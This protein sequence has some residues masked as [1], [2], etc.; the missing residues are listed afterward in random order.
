MGGATAG[1]DTVMTAGVVPCA[2]AHV[3]GPTMPSGVIPRCACHVFVAATVAGPNLP[4][5][6]TPM[7]VC[8]STT[9][10]P[11]DPCWIVVRAPSGPAG[12]MLTGMVGTIGGAVGIGMVVPGGG[13]VATA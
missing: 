13:D 7:S 11:V 4:S 2:A 12:G 5:G 9:S 6:V 1:A 3:F 8:Q 10:G